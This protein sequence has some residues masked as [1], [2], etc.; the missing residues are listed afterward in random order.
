MSRHVLDELFD[1]S[2]HEQL[3]ARRIAIDK[4]G[5]G[6]GKTGWLDEHIL[7]AL[8]GSEKTF[9]TRDHGFYRRSAA[10]SSYCIVY[11]EVPLAEMA[12]YIR[13]IL[14]HPQFNTHAK[15]LGK[16]IKVTSQRIEFWQRDR[17]TKSIM[18]WSGTETFA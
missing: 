2:I 18:R 7:Q 13:R 6:F 4:I 8:H 15:R 3:K 10:H 1:E 11:Y 9:H 17:S 12:A 5:A 14:R 16:V